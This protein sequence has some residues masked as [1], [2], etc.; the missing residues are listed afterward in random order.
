MKNILSS[1]FKDNSPDKIVVNDNE[2]EDK[3]ILYKKIEDN[4]YYELDKDNLILNAFI[5]ILLLF[6]LFGISIIISMIIAIMIFIPIRI[7]MKAIWKEK[8]IKIK[9]NN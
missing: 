4:N 2:L 1:K 5:K 6:Q 9:F 3:I 7:V 8:L